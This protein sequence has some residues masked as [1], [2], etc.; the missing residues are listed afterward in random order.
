MKK[1][2]IVMLTVVLLSVVGLT[3]YYINAFLTDLGS[4]E[5][6]VNVGEVKVIARAFREDSNHLLT[7]LDYVDIGN[8]VKKKGIYDINIVDRNSPSYI[9]NVRL[10]VDVHSKQETY[11]RLKIHEQL[12]LTRIT[13]DSSKP[14]LPEIKTE[15]SLLMEEPT[16]FNY[17]FNVN[18]DNI[19]DSEHLNW[20]DNRTVD[21]Y[22]Y[23]KLPVQ[24]VSEGVPT[25]IGL[26]KSYYSDSRYV[27][28]PSGYSLQLAITVEAVQ[29][30]GG[31]QNNWGLIEPPWG[32]NW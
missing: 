15:I 27:S 26:I 32:G 31:P 7:E 16:D 29:I 8:G 3:S 19:N 4:R 1:F 2:F 18:N 30:Y 10:Y 6:S 13:I 11:I 24:R 12:T 17:I 22:I 9:E 23:Y 28:Q 14:H 20:Y 21:G 25:R 5:G